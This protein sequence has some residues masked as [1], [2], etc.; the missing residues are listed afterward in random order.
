[1]KLSL[2][3]RLTLV[4]VAMMGVATACSVYANLYMR[5]LQERIHSIVEESVPLVVVTEKMDADKAAVQT[6]LKNYLLENE[7]GKLPA[8]EDKIRALTVA[9]NECEME[10]GKAIENLTHDH[11]KAEM[12]KIWAEA[13]TTIMPDFDREAIHALAAHKDYLELHAL[14]IAKT[15]QHEEQGM[16]LFGLLADMQSQS[17][18]PGSVLSTVT[19]MERVHLYMMHA[20]EEYVTKGQMATSQERLELRK[21]FVEHSEEFGRWLKVL[22]DS[23]DPVQN[24]TLVSEISSA[25]TEFV[26]SA[27][28]EGQLFSLYERELAAYAKTLDHITNTDALG[29]LDS[30]TAEELTMLASNHLSETQK[31]T[32]HLM[33]W[34]CMA[35]VI[36]S[37]GGILGCWV[38]MNLIS[39]RIVK[40]IL[41]LSD[42]ARA[43]AKGDLSRK[44]EF[45]AN[46][47]IG[48]LCAAFNEM[49][50]DLR[51]T[52]T[53]IE[54]LDREIHERQKAEE[55]LDDLN[56]KLEAANREL[57]RTN[58]ELQ[59][60]AH[61][62]AHDLKTPLRAIGT[63]ADWIATDYAD[64]FD[65]QGQEQVRL[66]VTK[67]KQ[68]AALIDDI[69]HY[70]GV[71]H[72]LQ[73][74]QPVDLNNLVAE[75]I[76]EIAPPDH[77]EL[78]VQKDLPTIVGK[79]THLI[80]IFQNLLG[81]A[82]KYMDK[83]RGN[84]KITCVEQEDSWTFSITDNGPGIDGR[85]F[86]K[87]FEIFQTLGRRGDGE[88]TGIGLSIVK[89]LVELNN[90]RVWVESEL[91]KGST[92]FFTLPKQEWGTT[93]EN[94]CSAKTGGYIGQT[95]EQAAWIPFL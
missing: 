38:V 1:M 4:T 36:V 37:A 5:S 93:A 56:R 74:P 6:E 42:A 59:E 33:K 46:D 64:K 54:N 55:A 81:N 66:L 72:S 77:I 26:S 43:L 63:L 88:S 22:Q 83:P 52:T 27:V 65:E 80:Q 24:N 76:A 87:I 31:R 79:K 44:V 20:D 15:E 57:I 90:G 29:R 58:K 34:T 10:I 70:S 18:N 60:F 61:I 62:A 89:K 84:I 21:R 47:E 78:A 32:T 16:R 3:K 53:S 9:H 85:Y 82:V 40:P 13:M 51:T 39:R 12:R 7:P 67:A 17:Q 11:P 45:S 86:E 92:F 41:A 50:E 2:Q 48:G 35:F 95:T 94:T 25:Y 14:R 73:K 49:A 30:R 75:V 91:G 69:L 23:W 28:G 71:G 8:L 68:M 19:S